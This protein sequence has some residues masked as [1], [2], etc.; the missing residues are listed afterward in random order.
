MEH[1]QC[2]AG[3]L[4]RVALP[5]QPGGEPC[6]EGKL[7]PGVERVPVDEV[8]EVPCARVVAARTQAGTPQVDAVVE[9]VLDVE[10]DVDVRD[11]NLHGML[12]DP[13]DFDSVADHLGT[14]D[15]LQETLAGLVM[16]VQ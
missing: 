3:G 7:T 13:R 11:R 1:L 12:V 4:G 8:R 10:I 5:T 14:F 9:V 6:G 15:R 16:P 2:L